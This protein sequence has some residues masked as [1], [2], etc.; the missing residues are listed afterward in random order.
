MN[1]YKQK[2]PELKIRYK[3]GCFVSSKISC[4]DD[5]A[6]LFRSVFDADLI[7][8]REEMILLLVNRA[9]H[10]L[11]YVKISAGGITGTVC[12]PRIVFA[13]AL[14]AGATGILV[15]HN[16]PSGNLCPSEQD[17]HLT[18]KLVSAGKIMDIPLLDH[19]IITSDSY[20][21]FSDNGL[22]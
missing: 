9:N 17:I 2:L 4:S 7:E 3:K 16:H 19:I 1:A 20:Y 21:S 15:A 13:S 12:D 18:R 22:L 11:G 10:P 14:C 8:Y 5:A 6:N